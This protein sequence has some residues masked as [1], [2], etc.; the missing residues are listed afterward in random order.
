MDILF[1][2]I[3]TALMIAAV[4]VTGSVAFTYG[5]FVA[6]AWLVLAVASF[7]VR[8]VLRRTPPG[9]G[10][11]ILL[12]SYLEYLLPLAGYAL[13]LNLL[14][15][16][17]VVAVKAFLAR[18]P[19][20]SGTGSSADAAS[21]AAGVY[22]AAKNVALLPYQ[23]VISLAFIVF[24]LV[25][26]AS[27]SGDREG[28]SRV[29]TGSF[30]LASVLSWCAVAVFGAAPSAILGLL[31]GASYR[32]GA[33]GLV[34]L[35]AAGAMLAFMHVGNA[36][37]ASSGRPVVS[38]IGGIGAA[39]VQIGL[40]FL[41]LPGADAASVPRLAAVATLAGSAFGAVV[42]GILNARMHGFRGWLWSM[43]SS[44]LAAAAAIGTAG[45]IEGRVFWVVQPCVAFVVFV[46]V[47]IATR[48][49]GRAD[50]DVMVG[51]VRRGAR[52]RDS[53]QA[54]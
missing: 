54:A 17:D 18:L 14:L 13:V 39:V 52:R 41:L 35:L 10:G 51:I 24:P 50:W 16:A 28:A 27:S 32:A 6:T 12:R 33:S 7:V 29:V 31:F 38:V 53:G 15:Q 1:S 45:L 40:L 42:S 3:K 21:V 20:L 2:T 19:G 4:V 44:I 46:A 34:I 30:R 23:A 37:L 49:V 43:V 36:V 5:A 9:K 48:G 26:T 8:G 22:G 11:G 47:L 25:S